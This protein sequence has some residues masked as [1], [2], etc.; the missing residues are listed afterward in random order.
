MQRH[1]WWGQLELNWIKFGSVPDNTAVGYVNAV[2][3][4]LHF[5]E[6][7]FFQIPDRQRPGRIAMLFSVVSV[8]KNSERLYY[9]KHITIYPADPSKPI[10]NIHYIKKG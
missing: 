6:I 5:D 7:Y 10:I 2:G 8:S 1:I 3:E 4:C 9:K